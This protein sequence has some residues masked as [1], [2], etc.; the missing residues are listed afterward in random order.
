LT[1]QQT[2]DKVVKALRLQGKPSFD[3]ETFSCLYRGPDNTKCA[4]GHLI[5]NDKYRPE[6]EEGSVHRE[7]IKYVIETEGYNLTLVVDLQLC[8]DMSATDTYHTNDS[9]MEKL[10]R[11][12]KKTA[13]EFNLVYTDPTI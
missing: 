11:R 12:L 13:R 9:F 3:P 4:A 8:H 1:N 2:F 5:P 7:D 6:F 10:E